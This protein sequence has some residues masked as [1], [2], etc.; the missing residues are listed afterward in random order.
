MADED[1]TVCPSRLHRPAIEVRCNHGLRY[2]VDAGATVQVVMP[3]EL[4]KAF[5]KWIGRSG[6]TLLKVPV[7]DGEDLPSYFVGLV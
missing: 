4:R 3:A 1:C 6:Y 7:D 2:R 5:E